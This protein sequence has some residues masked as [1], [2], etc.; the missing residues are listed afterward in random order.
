MM[1]LKH[2]CPLCGSKN[3]NHLYDIDEHKKEVITYICNNCGFIFL[4]P[5]PSIQERGVFYQ[6]TSVL[7]SECSILI[8]DDK[9]FFQFESI[10]RTRLNI[11]ADNLEKYLWS[12]N[13]QKSVLE[14]GCGTGSFL[15]LMRG[16]GWNVLGLEPDIT[17]AK[18]AEERYNIEIKG[19][20]I[21]ELSTDQKFDLI[22]TFHVIEHVDDPNIFLAA[23][24][25][26]LV[27]DGYL[28]L[29]C[30]SIDKW[31]G[32]SI[33]FFLQD[34]HIN[35]FSQKTLFA[36]LAKAGFKTIA[37]GWNGNGLWVIAKKDKTAN[38]PVVWD[39]PERIKHIVREAYRNSRN[40]NLLAKRFISRVQRGLTLIKEDP[41]QFPYKVL[42][43][44]QKRFGVPANTRISSTK[45]QIIDI[46]ELNA[47]DIGI[48]PVITTNTKDTVLKIAHLGVHGNISN[49][50]DTLLFP[51][52]R[53][54]FQT[55]LA[56]T[57]FTLFQVRDK[58]T[59]ETIDAI[60]QHDALVIG[61]GGLFLADTNPNNLSGWQW[62]CPIELLEQI[63][64]PIIVFSVGYNKFRGQQEFADVFHRS[65]CKLVE[66]SAFFGL[67]NYGS[68]QQLKNYLPEELHERLVFQPCPTTVLSKFYAGIPQI[69]NND[70]DQRVITINI[71]LDRHHL[72][73]GHKEDE[74][75][76][77]IAEVLLSFQQDGWQIR[78][79]NHCPVDTETSFWFRAKSLYSEERN[80]HYL[81]PQASI[82]AYSDVS[83]AIGMRG[84]AQMIPFGLG[85]PILS[86][87]SHDKLGFFLEDIEHPEWGIEVKSSNFRDEL[88][89]KISSILGNRQATIYQLE[90]AQDRLWN[91]TCDNLTHIRKII[92]AS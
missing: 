46:R 1:K 45:N 3:Y 54:L 84:H 47:N 10:A 90:K 43:K 42:A 80:L 49:G 7:K 38:L 73:F 69:S 5:R 30:P 32:D 4:S 37:N 33:D 21:Q 74:I 29:E 65:V 17:Y 40:Q 12:N 68:I 63:K 83:L 52:V 91:V 87:I 55:N 66:K 92:Q 75:L 78:L 51:A 36:F 71:A 60:N 67:R 34:V 79:L 61:G 31:Y 41:L 81:P 9:N 22:A 48:T 89:D 70:N 72:R 13:H 8:S 64:I 62:P 77:N 20:F 11:L 76:W 23:I 15:R 58:V 39:D 57:N 27:D 14:V 2:S 19:E 86:L 85:C 35:T 59:Q 50:G 6:K 53:Y 28:F 44:V 82:D 26:C 18:A 24:H 16:C 88:T 25:S 56:P